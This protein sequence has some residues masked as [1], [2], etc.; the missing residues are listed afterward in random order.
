MIPFSF[1]SNLAGR[2]RLLAV[3][4]FKIIEAEFY[5]YFYK[6]A[7][8]YLQVLCRVLTSRDIFFLIHLNEIFALQESRTIK[9]IK[10]CKAFSND[11]LAVCPSF[12]AEQ[13]YWFLDFSLSWDFLAK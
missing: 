8:T 12:F 6:F 2:Y 7:K 1:R 9:E 5:N 13:S 3:Q 11:S 10:V 4:Y